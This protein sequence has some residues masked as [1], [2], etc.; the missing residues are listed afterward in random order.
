MTLNALNAALFSRLAG[1]VTAAGSA[2]FFNQAP[3]D[4]PLPYIVFDY[5]ADTDENLDCNR[6]RDA[7]LFIR[8]Y[9]ASQAQAGTIDAQIDSL[10]HFQP[11]TVT[12]WT[13]FWIARENGFSITETDPAGRLTHVAGADYRI[14]LDKE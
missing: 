11:L 4:Q 13:N 6:T 2:V 8:G 1:T 3:D 12:G 10:L 9:A 14:R 5:V 7:V